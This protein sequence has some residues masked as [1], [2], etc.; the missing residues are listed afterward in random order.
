MTSRF[1]AV[2][3]E[4][5]IQL[6]TRPENDT[7]TTADVLEDCGCEAHCG[8]RFDAARLRDMIAG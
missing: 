7:R 2:R 4:R 6:G 1:D 3:R 5:P 8:V